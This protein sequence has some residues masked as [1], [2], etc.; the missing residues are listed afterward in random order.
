MLYYYIL[1]A[2]EVLLVVIKDV[3]EKTQKIQLYPCMYFF[4][5]HEL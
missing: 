2:E 4:T 1:S 3:V 5:F